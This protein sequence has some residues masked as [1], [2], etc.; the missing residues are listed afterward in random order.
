M[1]NIFI[2]SHEREGGISV[3][4]KRPTVRELYPQAFTVLDNIRG[5]CATYHTSDE[6]IVKAMRGSRSTLARR[7]RM[8]WQFTIDEL[9]DIAALWS[10]TPEQL[11][12]K[13]RY[14]VPPLL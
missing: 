12:V 9:T 6:E 7:K 13:P 10:M 11:M 1:P 8:P 14:E 3:P 2:Y 5:L 4:K